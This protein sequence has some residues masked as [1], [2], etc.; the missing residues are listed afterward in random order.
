MDHV[1]MEADSLE[2][3]LTTFKDSQAYTAHL[4]EDVLP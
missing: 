4:F 3:F 1:G 2:Q